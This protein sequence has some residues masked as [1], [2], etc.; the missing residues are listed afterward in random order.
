[1]ATINFGDHMQ[2]FFLGALVLMAGTSR[3]MSLDNCWENIKYGCNRLGIGV[4]KTL[5]DPAEWVGPVLTAVVVA[6]SMVNG[7]PVNGIPLSI[8][9]IPLV[10]AGLSVIKYAIPEEYYPSNTFVRTVLEHPYGLCLTGLFAKFARVAVD[11]KDS[12]IFRG[13]G[14]L[15]AGY[16]GIRWAHKYLAKDKAQQNDPEPTEDDTEQ[17]EE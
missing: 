10:G 14:V 6:P 12:T 4:A 1:M 3:A 7:T 2:K 15:T 5:T 11:A 17:I 16:T 8:K 13:L 9:M